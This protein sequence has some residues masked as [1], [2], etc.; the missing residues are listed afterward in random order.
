[1]DNDGFV[2]EQEFKMDTITDLVINYE[3]KI[4]KILPQVE[5]GSDNKEKRKGADAKA[6]T[7]ETEIEKEGTEVEIKAKQDEE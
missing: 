6:D 4:K 5:E 2:L 7:E 3:D 1:M